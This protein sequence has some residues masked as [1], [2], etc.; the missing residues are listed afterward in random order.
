MQL[1]LEVNFRRGAGDC[2]WT[3][4]MPSQGIPGP[5]QALHYGCISTALPLLPVHILHTEGHSL[6][7]GPCLWPRPPGCS[8]TCS[9]CQLQEELEKGGR[10]PQR[11]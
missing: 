5:W 10:R 1:L 7:T 8:P 6:C 4:I 2:V 9:H 11:K 3:S